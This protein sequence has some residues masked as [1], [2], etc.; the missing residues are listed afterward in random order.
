MTE[1]EI[2]I[3]IALG[4]LPLWKQIELGLAK[5]TETNRTGDKI[6]LSYAYDPSVI[7]V[8]DPNIPGERAK[9]IKYF[10]R[11]SIINDDIYDYGAK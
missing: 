1:K 10:I 3:Q 9:A 4:T 8:Y 11:H 7:Y 5:F 6:A 2:D